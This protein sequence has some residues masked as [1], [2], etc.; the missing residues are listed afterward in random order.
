MDGIIR[1]AT[2]LDATRIV[3]MGRKFF[4]SGPYRAQLED[5]PD[6]FL[7]FTSAL[8][9]NPNARVLVAEDAS[10][11]VVGVLAILISPH[12]LSGELVGVELI[13]YVEPE[14]RGQVSLELFWAAEKL[15][16][17]MGAVRMQFTAPNEQVGAIY[18][19][20]HYTQLEVGYQRSL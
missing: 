18:K 10:G 9:G 4:L 1:E 13:W 7:G 17:E 12:Y 2:A 11:F 5:K 20:L 14:H 19:R 15:A 3:E 6:R 16:K 8:I